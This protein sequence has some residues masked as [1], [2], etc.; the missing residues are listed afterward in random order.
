MELIRIYTF[1]QFPTHIQVV[2]ETRAKYKEIINKQ[3][4]AITKLANPGK[5]GKPRYKKINGQDIY[6][7]GIEGNFDMTKVIDAMKT[8]IRTQL[9]D[10]LPINFIDENGEPFRVAIRGQLH[11]PYD[12][13]YHKMIDGELRPPK[14]TKKEIKWDVGN[15]GY[16][17]SKAFDDA[18]QPP[19]DDVPTKN[20]KKK[21]KIKDEWWHGLIADDCV[22][23]VA[24]TGEMWHYP[25]ERIED[26]QLVFQIFKVK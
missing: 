12:Q 10:E 2:G 16:A 24:A 6:R 21:K 1:Q 7:R 22:K 25:I 13:E 11:I 18:L 14:D 3:G 20:A 9:K 5:A 26:R 17:W 23:Y 15:I 8:Y 19:K 4:V